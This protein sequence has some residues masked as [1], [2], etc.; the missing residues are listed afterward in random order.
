MGRSVSEI[1]DA[2]HLV[3]ERDVGVLDLGWAFDLRGWIG[4]D[5]AG[6]ISSFGV[7]RGVYWR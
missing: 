2:G 3:W 4:F 5:G 6:A 7:G 1:F